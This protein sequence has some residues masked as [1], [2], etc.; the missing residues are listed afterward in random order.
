MYQGLSAGMDQ[1]RRYLNPKLVNHIVLITDGHTF[2][3]QE[4]CLAL[5]RT[6]R[7]EG[8]SI[9]AMGLG[10]DWN[11]DF[12]DKIAS[13]TGGSSAYIDSAGSVVRFLNDH[14]RAL[15]NAFA[16]RMNISIAPDPDLQLEMAFKL[17]PAP[18]PLGIEDGLI[19]LG[20]LQHNRPISILLQLQLPANAPEGFRPIARILVKGDILEN[21]PQDFQ[22]L[23]DISIEISNN[24]GQDAPPPAIME[25]LS[26]LTLYRMQERAKEALDR[27]DIGEATRR[28]ENLATRLLDMGEEE[29]AGQALAEARRVAHTNML[30][31]R[32]KKTLKFHT[33]LLLAG[34][35]SEDGN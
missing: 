34:S 6:A 8:V 3:D 29:L 5:A 18:Q 19:P 21:D 2:G 16:E 22:T 32:G 14:V 27:G 20:N 33:R 4:Q 1:V 31:D 11:D 12:L 30:S 10:H 13:S 23:S 7:G 25:A 17:T 24:A 28:L 9:S 35:A 15:A 26:K